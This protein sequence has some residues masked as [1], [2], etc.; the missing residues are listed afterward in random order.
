MCALP[1]FC[2]TGIACVYHR[3][4]GRVLFT[5]AEATQGSGAKT[6]MPFT[7]NDMH[8]KMGWF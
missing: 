2:G 1:G 6:F 7:L 8:P 3:K 4:R 5:T